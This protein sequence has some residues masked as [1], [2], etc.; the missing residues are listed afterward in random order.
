MAGI[1]PINNNC[2]DVVKKAS[3]RT[4]LTSSANELEIF[5]NLCI[6]RV[7]YKSSTCTLY[8]VDSF[9][10]SVS[11][12]ILKVFKGFDQEPDIE[13]RLIPIFM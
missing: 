10:I 2:N 3:R 4:T 13:Q 12:I 9:S 5:Y 8:Y 6:G 11:E 7:H 1:G